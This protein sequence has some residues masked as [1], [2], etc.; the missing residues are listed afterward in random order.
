MCVCVCFYHLVGHNIWWPSWTYLIGLQFV[1]VTLAVSLL[2]HMFPMHCVVNTKGY[3]N[4]F[5]LLQ[6]NF[7][8]QTVWETLS[9]LQCSFPCVRGGNFLQILNYTHIFCAYVAIG[10]CT[11]VCWLIATTT[12]DCGP[13]RQ[14]NELNGNETV[15]AAAP[16]LFVRHKQTERWQVR[17]ES[18]YDALHSTNSELVWPTIETVD[19]SPLVTLAHHWVHCVSVARDLD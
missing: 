6:V 7:P 11:L 18:I 15:S 1:L 17:N 10:R 16:Y 3:G 14:N 12:A 4:P 2:G 8:K 13:I 5:C 19:H 9:L